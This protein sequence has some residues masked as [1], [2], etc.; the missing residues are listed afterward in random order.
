MIEADN[1]NVEGGFYAIKFNVL[2]A[3]SLLFVFV[4]PK[5]YCFNHSYALQVSFFSLIT[6]VVVTSSFWLCS[7]FCADKIATSYVFE[8]AT[9]TCPQTCRQSNHYISALRTGPL[10]KYPSLLLNAH[11]MPKEMLEDSDFFQHCES[12]LF[13]AVCFLIICF[14][15]PL[16]KLT[17]HFCDFFSFCFSDQMTTNSRHLK[18]R[19]L[20]NL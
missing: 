5:L 19:E 13:S 8:G 17:N 4:K 20:T 11:Q 15:L 10:Q 12:L 2:K 3:N 7:K 6:N 16:M 1:S 9:C 18:N 14:F